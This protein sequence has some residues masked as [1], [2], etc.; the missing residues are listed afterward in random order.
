MKHS[1]TRLCA[2]LVCV[3]LASISNAGWAHA[4]ENSLLE[5]SIAPK[6][7][8]RTVWR[9]GSINLNI[10]P[11]TSLTTLNDSHIYAMILYSADTPL[12][13]KLRGDARVVQ[14]H[15]PDPQTQRG[16]AMVRVAHLNELEEYA[17]MAHEGLGCGNIQVV[18]LNDTVASYIAVTDPVFAP[19]QKIDAV[20]KATDAATNTKWSG[21][22]QSMVAH[23]TRYHTNSNREQVTNTVKSAW[24]SAAAGKIPGFTVEAV[25]HSTT[26]QKSV[27]AKIPGTTEASTTVIIGCHLDSI[28]T[29]TSN[30]PGADDNATGVATVAEIIRAVGEL[31]WKFNRT[32]EFHAYAAEEI[33]LVGSAAIA[34]SYKSSS[35]AVASMM[36]IDMNGYSDSDKIWIVKEDSSTNLKRGL[37]DLINTYLGGNVQE[38][39]LT[40]GT[41]DHKS[42][43]SKGFQA[44]FPF[45]NPDNHNPNIHKAT[46]TMD[47]FNQPNL[48]LRFIKLGVA[49]LAHYAGFV[50]DGST[51]DGNTGGGSTPS[52]PTTPGSLSNDIKIAM[53][54]A[55]QANGFYLAAATGVQYASVEAC[56][57]S[58]TNTEVC[59]GVIL[60]LYFAKSKNGRYF[61]ADDFNTTVMQ[62]GERWRFAAYDSSSRLAARRDVIITAKTTNTTP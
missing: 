22:V 47:K 5:V 39:S 10:K 34:S 45:E 4:Q 61:F 24:E 49:Y 50:A 35:R 40:A 8:E 17:E 46:D 15:D 19:T 42:W 25:T 56:R 1:L 59:G 33:G 11:G 26:S 3:A 6:P 41:S 30:A 62:V 48:P 38:A 51:G 31:G 52:T 29:D 21:I 43:T 36:Q 32:V 44:A 7:E 55:D 2:S 28:S 14:F 23:G 57:V 60:P 16:F 20:Q 12:E 13:Q 54:K 9:H 37:T 18:D 27:V 53:V 58:T